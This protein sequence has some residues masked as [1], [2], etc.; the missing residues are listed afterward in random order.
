MVK[1]S[2]EKLQQIYHDVDKLYQ[3][4]L[5]NGRHFYDRWQDKIERQEFIEPAK[6][7]AAYLA[8]RQKDL[9][10][11]QQ[12]LIPLGLSSIGRS[13]AKTIVTLQALRANLANLSGL[14]TSHDYPTVEQFNQGIQ[15]L[16]QQADKIF[17]P[18][19]DDY[20]TRIMVTL[21][22][23]AA[24]DVKLIDEMLLAG[25]NVA[26]INCSHDNPEIWQQ[27]IELVRE[28]SKK[29]NKTVK[30]Q[31]DIAGPKLRVDWV[32]SYFK[33]NKV[34]VGDHVKLLP[35]IKHIE[36]NSDIVVYL[37]CPFPCV[38]EQIKEGDRVF[39]DDGAFRAHVIEVQEHGAVLKIDQV[40]GGSGRIKAQKGINFPDTLLNIDIIDQK[41]EQDIAFAAKW[42]DI[43]NLSFIRSKKDV[44]EIQ[45][46]LKE[47]LGE[48]ANQMQLMVKIENSQAVENI[49][50]I[51][52]TA[53]SKNPT[54]I[55][56]ARGD[57]AVE[58]GYVRL[59]E[60]QQE[61]MWICEAASVP[62]VWATE[63]LANLVDNGIPARA[64]LTDVVE[65]A[66]S[67]CVMLNKGD[68]IVPAIKL[69][70]KIL[71]KVEINQF[72]KTP[73]LRALNIAK[74]AGQYTLDE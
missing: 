61:I 70:A 1:N 10:P 66:R 45:A 57:L 62:V 53:A 13:E 19:P 33:K 55:M 59:A 43:I 9:R 37:G 34:K 7:L 67:E 15:L 69:L 2:R 17:G 12:K 51:I 64:E 32:F 41:D 30:I 58:A 6:N 35:D 46:K 40:K 31:M 50:E 74:Q 49:V 18:A 47:L 54:A 8:L 44:E 26:R 63:V 25:M 20:R 72:K 65:G 56:I 71:K 68:F 60:L 42:A 4:V 14:E 29:L 11:L 39:F 21:P 38:Y 3:Y 23:E 52:M 27:M 16:D 28:R 24:T 73:Q 22:T 36:D 48:K 5:T